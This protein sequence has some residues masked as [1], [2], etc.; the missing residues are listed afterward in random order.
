MVETGDPAPPFTLPS[1]AGGEV[2]L[3]DELR[4][5]P[6]IL[7]TNRGYW[8]SYCAEQLQTYSHHAYDLWRNHGTTVLP[9]L[10]DP[11]PRLV[12]M[13]DRFDLRL[14]LL[15]DTDL[16]VVDTYARTERT[17]RHGEI[18]VAATVIIDGDGTIR[19]RQVA[20]DPSDRTYANYARH[21][22]TNG[23]AA[24]YPEHPA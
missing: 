5:G 3:A 2:S 13:R 8:C 10:G 18:P 14:Q 9:I 4:S 6:V 7:V 21:F 15:A 19:Y 24:P 22:V 16:E 1:T 11:V 17:D 23:M 20:S 12:E